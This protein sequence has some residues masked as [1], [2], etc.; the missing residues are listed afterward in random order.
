LRSVRRCRIGTLALIQQ[1]LL[2]FVREWHGLWS[3]LGDGPDGWPRYRG[4]LDAARRDVLAVGA[5]EIALGNTIGFIQALDAWVFIPALADRRSDADP[6]VRQ[7]PGVVAQAV[8]TAPAIVAATGDPVS[9]ARC[10]S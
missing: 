4:L 5:A 10:S 2:T 8:I 1:R 3:A 7:R 9:I 6:E